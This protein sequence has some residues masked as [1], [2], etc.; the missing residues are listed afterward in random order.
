MQKNYGRGDFVDA[1]SEN[2]KGTIMAEPEINDAAIA[3]LISNKIASGVYEST[4]VVAWAMLRALPLLK[5][6]ANS[7][8]GAKK[9]K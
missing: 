4:D 5:A 2:G 8:D 3:Q 9:G 6:I 1:G 7:L